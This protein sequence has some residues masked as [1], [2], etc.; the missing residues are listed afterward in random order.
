MDELKI[1]PNDPK[2]RRREG[3]DETGPNYSRYF[4]QL[5]GAVHLPQ[6]TEVKST[7]PEVMFQKIIYDGL[8]GHLFL[9]D[10]QV[11]YDLPHSRMI[12]RKP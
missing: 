3:R 1:D 10:F 11:T 9:R 8:V 5:K 12:F 6:S 2:V 7:D 4:T